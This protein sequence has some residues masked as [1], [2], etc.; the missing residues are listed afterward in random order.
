MIAGLFLS[1]SFLPALTG[2]GVSEDNADL[3]CDEARS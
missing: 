3:F 2:I 1:E